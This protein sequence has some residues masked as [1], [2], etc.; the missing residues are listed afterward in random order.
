MK[1]ALAIVLLLLALAPFHAE[2][3]EPQPEILGVRLGMEKKEARER[4]G[5]LGK[6]ERE[7]RKRQEVW[8]LTDARYSHLLLGF[9]PE[10]RV[11]YVTAIARP[12]GKRVPYTEVGDPKTATR[13]GA[14]GH[15]KYVWEVAEKSG[16][17]GFLVMARGTDPRFL[18]TWS[19]KRKE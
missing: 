13:T 15:R 2:A 9:D 7:E 17:Q 1:R 16:G 3:R 6:L 19:V 4:L 18:S 5:Q 10:G 11:R 14:P 12:Q 8:Q